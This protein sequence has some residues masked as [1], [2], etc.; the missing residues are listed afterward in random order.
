[1]GVLMGVIFFGL[2][3]GILLGI[4]WLSGLFLFR[5]DGYATPA[6]RKLGIATFVCFCPATIYVIYLLLR[7]GAMAI[8]LCLFGLIA[9]TGS[10]IAGAWRKRQS[11]TQ[12]RGQLLMKR[13]VILLSSSMASALILFGAAL[14]AGQDYYFWWTGRL[15]PST[16]AILSQGLYASTLVWLFVSAIGFRITRR[17]SKQEGGRQP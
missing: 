7:S 10:L 4:S 2:G 5:N 9:G 6:I 16:K 11:N 15:S 13:G 8:P 1:M 14:L 12:E 3:A 17:A